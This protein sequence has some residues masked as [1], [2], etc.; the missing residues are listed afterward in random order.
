M[1]KKIF[2]IVNLIAFIFLF[3]GIDYFDYKRIDRSLE[4][5]IKNCVVYSL[6]YA[7]DKDITF[8]IKEEI[9]EQKLKELAIVIIDNYG[10]E[11]YSLDVGY[12]INN[13]YCKGVSVCFDYKIKYYHKK[14]DINYL[15]NS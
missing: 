12:F 6:K 11:H 4:I 8:Y 1:K 5:S 3:V 7:L 14:M 10:I 13:N 2:C 15:L 9:F